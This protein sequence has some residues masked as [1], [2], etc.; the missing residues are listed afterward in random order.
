MNEEQLNHAVE[1]L[2]DGMKKCLEVWS[3]QTLCDMAI[4]AGFAVLVLIVA[5]VYLERLKDRLV[6]RAA[7]EFW[8][9]LSDFVPDMLLGGIALIAILITNNDI[10]ADIKIALPWVPLGFVL[11]TIALVI[12]LFHGGHSIGSKAWFLATALIALACLSN[13][14]GFTFV[15]EGAGEEYLTPH[16]NAAAFWNALGHMRSSENPDLSM[17]TFL[18]ASPAILLTLAWAAIA[19]VVR[20]TRW[21][22]LAHSQSQPKA[23]G[24]E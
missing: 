4:L 12:R 11:M 24:H 1:K 18:W 15:M 5:R 23:A 21:A 7:R 20:T 22:R 9:S 6:L 10:M 13:W 3:L 2:N 8:E 16:P 19:G 14:F 17:T